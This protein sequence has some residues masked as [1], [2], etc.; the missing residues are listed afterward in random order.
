MA[1]V[2]QPQKGKGDKSN[3]RESASSPVHVVLT[4][5][6]TLTAGNF[7]FGGPFVVGF[8]VKG[9]SAL[10]LS[11]YPEGGRGLWDC[12]CPSYHILTPVHVH[13]ETRVNQE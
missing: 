7:E 2:S 13:S 11:A 10:A 3:M 6:A 8:G 1:L 9:E 4:T 12:P 5:S